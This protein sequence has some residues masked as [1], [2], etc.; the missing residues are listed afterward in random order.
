LR[1]EQ[2][3]FNDIDKESSMLAEHFIDNHLKVNPYGMKSTQ[4]KHELQAFYQVND[5]T[6]VRNTLRKIVGSLM[7][8]AGIQ[9]YTKVDDYFITYR[10]R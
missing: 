8:D 3:S 2:R 1:Q 4:I 7:T 5:P 6:L 9:D 10:R